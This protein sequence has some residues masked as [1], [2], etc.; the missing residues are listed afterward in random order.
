MKLGT[1]V[2]V[3]ELNRFTVSAAMCRGSYAHTAFGSSLSPVSVVTVSVQRGL[4]FQMFIST[5]LL[6][7]TG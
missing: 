4:Q 2:N 5:S 6:L 3:A 1:A 7:F